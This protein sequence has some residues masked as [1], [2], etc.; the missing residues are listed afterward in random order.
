MRVSTAIILAAGRG[1]RME[2]L[3]LNKPK[4]LTAIGEQTFLSKLLYQL[5]MLKVQRIV[6][7]IGYKSEKIKEYLKINFPNLT[8]EYVENTEWNV[9]NN[10][11]SLVK[12]LEVVR[13]DF[14]LIESDLIIQDQILEAMM[15]PNRIALGDLEEGMQ[16]SIVSLDGQLFAQKMDQNTP[17]K[18]FLKQEKWYKTINIYS[19]E[20]NTFEC[21]ILP[22]L[23]D[24]LHNGEIHQYYEKAIARA[25]EKTPLRLKAILANN[26]LWWEIDTP[27][28]LLSFFKS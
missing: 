2:H 23:F 3:T 4:C 19:F 15:I 7:V 12:A 16:G 28:D 18:L 26:S 6:I 13:E 1:C 10:L 9:S 14:M 8:V 25:L 22:E 21:M 5:Q 20:W 17:D 27:S 24:A 11:V